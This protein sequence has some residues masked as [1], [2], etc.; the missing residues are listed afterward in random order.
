MNPHLEQALCHFTEDVSVLTMLLA[1]G[2]D[3]IAMKRRGSGQELGRLEKADRGLIVAASG[4]RSAYATAFHVVLD[5][6]VV[7]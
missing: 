6:W 2:A 5:G 1:N 3:V 7:D 4:T